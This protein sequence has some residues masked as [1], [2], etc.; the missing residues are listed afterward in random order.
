MVIRDRDTTAVYTNNP[1]SGAFRTFGGMQ[2]QFATESMMDMAAEALEMDPFE[3]RRVN[4]MKIGST[5]HTQ[6]KLTAASLDRCLD[7]AEK[8]SR[9]EKGTPNVR[10]GKRSD[11]HGHDTR[12][13]CTFGARFADSMK[14]VTYRNACCTVIFAS[15]SS[16]RLWLPST[17]IRE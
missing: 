4:M 5:T 15:V 13:P 3:I 11:L 12:P 17:S 16:P 7:A 9:W 8:E 10:G 2:A 6:H 14:A 1:P